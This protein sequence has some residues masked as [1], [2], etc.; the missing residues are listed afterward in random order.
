MVTANAAD[1]ARLTDRMGALRP[2]ALADLVVFRATGSEDA[3]RAVLQAGTAD[4][5]LVLVG[6]RPVYGD[7]T[8]LEALGTLAEGCE[9]LPVEICGASKVA[10]LERE[11]GVDFATLQQANISSYGLFFCGTPPG[12]PTCIPSRSG[13]YTGRIEENDLDGDGLINEKDNCPKIFNPVRPMDAGSTGG[14]RRRRDRR[15]LR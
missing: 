6:G 2:G 4:V 7:A 10:C 3:Y 1:A 13:E 5:A 9:K 15:A 8:L 12:E 14:W 11:I